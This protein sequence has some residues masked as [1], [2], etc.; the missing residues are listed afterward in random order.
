MATQTTVSMIYT[1]ANVLLHLVT[2]VA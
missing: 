2:M 1:M